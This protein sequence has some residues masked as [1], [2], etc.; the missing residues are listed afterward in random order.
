MLQALLHGKLSREHENIEDILT[1]LVF[2][3]LKYCNS[4]LTVRLLSRAQFIDGQ[5]AFDP[6]LLSRPDVT[7]SNWCFWPYWAE[8]DCIPCEPDVVFRVAIPGHEPTEVLVE[9]KLNAGKSSYSDDGIQPNDQLAREWDNLAIRALSN[10]ARPLLIYLTSHFALPRSEIEIS[11][12]EF[13]R[14]RGT[15]P[16]IAWLSWRAL[17][18]TLTVGSADPLQND[19]HALLER[20]GLTDFSGVARVNARRISWHFDEWASTW[21]TKHFYLQWSFN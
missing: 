1:S 14:K 6:K 11:I 12:A 10:G 3:L 4:S 15:T 13:E 5:P 17:H 16:A 2:G 8:R 20:M 19:L 21:S 7:V 9:A 18:Q